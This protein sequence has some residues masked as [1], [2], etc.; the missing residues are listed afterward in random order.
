M[1]TRLRD[2]INDM[3]PAW[4][5]MKGTPS[6]RTLFL[7]ISANSPFSLLCFLPSPLPSV[8]LPGRLS[9]NFGVFPLNGHLY[10]TVFSLKLTPRQCRTQTLRGGG[11][12]QPLHKGGAVPPPN[13]FWFKN[14]A[15][16][17]GSATA[18]VVPCPSSVI[19]SDSLYVRHLYETHN[20][21]CPSTMRLR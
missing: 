14:K 9:S 7:F 4:Q 8:Q 17:P 1:K 20:G 12:I 11:V 10:Q 21:C 18:R 5:V 16:P 3:K 13:F 6:I 19:F 15:P 2:I